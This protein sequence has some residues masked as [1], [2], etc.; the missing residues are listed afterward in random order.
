[1][2]LLTNNH[3]N[4]FKNKIILFTKKFLLLF[5]KNI[6]LLKKIT[7]QFFDILK[8]KKCSFSGIFELKRIFFFGWKFWSFDLKHP[9]KLESA[10]I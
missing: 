8:K 10:W 9:M 4:N 7:F 1:M 5:Q 6:S 3:D 2:I